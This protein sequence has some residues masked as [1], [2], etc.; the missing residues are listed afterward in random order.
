[1]T[2]IAM[3][4]CLNV[5]CR[6]RFLSNVEGAKSLCD[7]FLDSYGEDR[8]AQLMKLILKYFSIQ[9][10]EKDLYLEKL[11]KEIEA[12]KIRRKHCYID[13]DFQVIYLYRNAIVVDMLGYLIFK[14]CIS[15]IW[16]HD[17]ARNW[18]KHRSNAARK[19]F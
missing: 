7:S 14:N 8:D 5:P 18:R 17:R 2:L 3:Y 19:G 13:H 9:V 4:S 12:C 1:M 11:E 10:A 15:D 6:T 16:I